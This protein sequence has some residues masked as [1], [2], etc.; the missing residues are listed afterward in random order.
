MLQDIPNKAFILAAGL[1]S[2]LRP[3]TN[4]TPKPLVKV[5]GR[6]LLDRTLDH[7]QDAGVGEVACNTHYLADQ[8]SDAISARPEF[9]AHISF[10]EELLETGGGIKNMLH[11]FDDAFYIINGDSLWENTQ[12]QNTLLSMANTWNPQEMDILILLQPID[13]MKLTKGVGDYR[14]DDNNMP[15]R[16]LDKR[17]EY[18]FT[19][20]RI[21][22]PRV[23]D[24][25]PNGAFSYLDLMDHAQ[26]K[27][28][29]YAL[30]H[31]GDWHHISTA[32]DL[33]AVNDAYEHIELQG[34]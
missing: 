19:S 9:I 21:N 14:L 13:T 24:N 6:T 29:L 5:D 16:S 27:G 10:E 23:F 28:R 2:R 17:G 25:T 12:G 34:K 18:M 31:K 4:D 3:Y 8:I 1:G 7:L 20:I 22:H 30:V 33:E 32:D 15:I 11:H 26:E